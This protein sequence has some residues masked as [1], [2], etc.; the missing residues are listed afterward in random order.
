MLHQPSDL[1]DRV[2]KWVL[3]RTSAI[4]VS[5]YATIKI[6]IPGFQGKNAAGPL[7]EIRTGG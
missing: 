2:N 1:L 4:V 6:Y 5:C 3:F 7:E